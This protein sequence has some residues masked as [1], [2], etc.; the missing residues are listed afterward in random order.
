MKNGEEDVPIDRFQTAFT[1]SPVGKVEIVIDVRVRVGF[2][3]A[4]FGSEIAGRLF[5]RR[6]TTVAPQGQRGVHE[7]PVARTA[8]IEGAFLADL[9]IG[10]LFVL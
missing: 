2:T 6:F 10:L 3:V 9:R 1:E 4:P 5:I 8:R 7:H